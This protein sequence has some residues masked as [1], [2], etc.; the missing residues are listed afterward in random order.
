MTA[1]HS[2][3]VRIFRRTLLAAACTAAATPVFAQS[4]AAPAAA[5]SA[6]EMQRVEVTGSR[7]K[8]IDAEGVSP[9]ETI[10]REDIAR[11]GAT[12]VREMLDSLSAT[13]TSGTLSDL[14]IG[15]AS[16]RESG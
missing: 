3:R 10:R 4:A 16:C 6:S 12:T 8:Q 1:Q 14:E 9:V 15:R 7:L 5:A 2:A 13:S 11:T